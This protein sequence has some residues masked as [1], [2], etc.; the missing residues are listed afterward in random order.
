[1]KHTQIFACFIARSQIAQRWS[2]ISYEI[3]RA[4]HLKTWGRG[5]FLGDQLV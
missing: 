5:D 3:W 2:H 4:G 1:M